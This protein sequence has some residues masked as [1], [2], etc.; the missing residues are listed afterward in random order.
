MMI[1]KKSAMR[2]ALYLALGLLLL[3]AVAL[4]I[5]GLTGTNFLKHSPYDSYTLQALAW[6]EGRFALDQNY[7]WLELAVYE[8]KYYVSF[9]PVP[10]IPMVVLSYIFG[11]NTPS[12][13]VTLLYFLGAYVAAFFLLRRTL[14]PKYAAA[15]AA[16]ALLGGSIADIAISGQG[17]AGSVWYQA[18]LLALL[19]TLLAFLLLS[20]ERKFGFVAGLVLIALAVGARPINAVYVPVLLTMLYQKMTAPKPL[21]R[22]RA[23]I[24]YLATPA[25]IALAYAA[26]N[27]LR[28]Q[29]PLEFGHRYLPEYVESGD[30]IFSLSFFW[31]NVLHSLRMFTLA[32]GRLEFPI[33]HGCAVYF[34]NP[35]LLYGAKSWAGR[36]RL[37]RADALDA[38]LILTVLLHAFLLFCHR[39]NGGWQ[40]GTRYLCDAVP[41]LLFLFARKRRHVTLM[42]GMAMGGLIAMNLYGTVVFHY[43]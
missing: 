41:A 16:F 37:R 35:M 10:A 9:P 36:L 11:G 19:C 15:V 43:L 7:E 23:M 28:F 42:E 17:F 26:Y 25:L 6:R 5:G 22:L 13:L 4:F 8:G 34:T 27:Y 38:L 31:Q 20:G 30:A 2:D 21:Q 40:Y 3:I 29:N 14:S 24:P 32:E 39:T 12:A 18:Q 33:F 1:A